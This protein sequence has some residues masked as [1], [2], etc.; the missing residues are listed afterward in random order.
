L[1]TGLPSRSRFRWATAISP[2]ARSA[3]ARHASWHATRIAPRGRR[4]A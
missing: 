4:T 1:R 2:K 3:S